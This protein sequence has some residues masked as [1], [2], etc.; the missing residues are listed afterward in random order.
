[1]DTKTP[2]EILNFR[3]ESGRFRL[4]LGRRVLV[5]FLQQFLL[6]LGELLRGLDQHLHIHVAA[7]TRAQHRHALAGKA[8]APARLRAVRHLHLGLAAVDR[9]DIEAP[10][11]RRRDHRDR[12]A[13]MQVGAVA[14]EKLMLREGE[15]NVEVA[16]RPAAHAG[17]ALA[18]E[19]NARAV[20][21]AGRHID[22]EGAFARDAAGAR[23]VRTRIVDRLTAALTGNA[24]ALQREEALLVTHLAG[25][26]AGRTGLRLRAGFR[27]RARAGLA[28]DRSR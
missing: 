24:G 20:F 3:E 21:H 6:A 19:A 5:E 15:E 12:H 27:A 18:R 2:E 28:G 4:R 23:A 16:V 7:L 9:R 17:L 22:R 13:A 25:A 11:E 26:A 14:L 10:A 1:M 8:E